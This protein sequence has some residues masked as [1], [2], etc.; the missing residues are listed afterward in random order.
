MIRLP[1]LPPPIELTPKI[2]D[3]LTKQFDLDRNK[4]VWNQPY[5]K[6]ALE[7][8]SNTK[9]A[10]CECDLKKESNYM[11]VEHFKPKSL[12]PT[13]V[14]EW[15]NLL[16]ACQRCNGAKRDF[17]DEVDGLIHPVFD[18]PREFISFLSD[19]AT[20]S[21]KNTKGK[22]SI[23]KI[24]LND[25]RVWCEREKVIKQLEKSL[26]NLSKWLE[27][28][29]IEEVENIVINNTT[30]IL[31]ECQNNKDYTATAA[32]FIATSETFLFIKNELE[33]RMWW[34]EEFELLWKGL[35]KYAL[36]KM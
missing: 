26:D 31:E 20:L 25:P 11:Q 16:P 18:E 36:D 28:K 35:R 21:Y 3:K 23:L 17:Y 13:L 7:Q 29:N 12:F 15:D 2:K 33:K 19:S 5:I 8:M 1:K 30:C 34:G 27:Q 6:A 4:D 10:Y 14:V 24:K 9:C 22:N 32:S